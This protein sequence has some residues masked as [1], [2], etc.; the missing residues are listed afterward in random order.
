MAV[1]FQLCKLVGR[2]LRK[3]LCEFC[4]NS[5]V[6]R[7]VLLYDHVVNKVHVAHNRERKK[8]VAVFCAQRDVVAAFC[9]EVCVSERYDRTLA[10]YLKV[11]V[12]ELVK[13]WCAETA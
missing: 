2:C 8:L 10:H 3:L 7:D 9:L 6:Y 12:V 4:T 13:T 5:I 11:M 1:G